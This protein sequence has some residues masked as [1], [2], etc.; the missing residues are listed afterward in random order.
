MGRQGLR[1]CRGRRSK[2]LAPA[3]RRRRDFA[4]LNH[5]VKRPEGALVIISPVSGF[6]NL[7]RRRT[8]LD[9]GAIGVKPTTSWGQVPRSVKTAR[10]SSAE[11]RWRNSTKRPGIGE[12]NLLAL[13]PQSHNSKV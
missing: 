11:E 6:L 8:P 12:I 4:T 1:V 5:L 2:R 9:L 13:L 10:I 7:E 3:L